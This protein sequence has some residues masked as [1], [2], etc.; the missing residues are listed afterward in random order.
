M[1]VTCT[2]ILYALMEQ[3]HAHLEKIFAIQGKFLLSLIG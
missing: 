1:F 3:S 2:S